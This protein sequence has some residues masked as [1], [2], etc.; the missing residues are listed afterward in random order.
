MEN[1]Q[2]RLQWDLKQFLEGISDKQFVQI[3]DSNIQDRMNHMNFDHSKFEFDL[4][5]MKDIDEDQSN[6]RN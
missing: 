3:Q 4:V 2:K 1:N 5:N 6:W